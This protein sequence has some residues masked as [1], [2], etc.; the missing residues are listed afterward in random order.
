M[1][2]TT[3]RI[4]VGGFVV[5]MLGI[6]SSAQA[7]TQDS[8]QPVVQQSATS[9]ALLKLPRRPLAE[10]LPVTIY[11]FQ[12]GV[13]G[14]TAQAATEMF[15]TALIRSG[16][17]RVVERAHLNDTVMR[18]KQMNSA[19]QTDGNVAQSQLRG[20]Q[21]IFDGTVSEA[22]IA[23]D[24]HSA[25]ISIGGLTIGGGKAKDSIAIDVRILDAASGDVLDS[26]AVS[27]V[28]KG[29]NANIGGTAALA[30]TLASMKGGNASALTPDIN[31]GTA[32]KD[33]SDEALRACIEAAVL[34]LIKRV[35]SVQEVK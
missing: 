23:A 10:R 11:E 9:Q 7:G 29:T 21:Y 30:S 27:K 4:L 31:I 20:A 24:Q 19:G 13:Q 33:G 28:L 3:T 14:V 2:H 18:E 5:A 16:Q 6:Q 34:E 1:R 35:Q 22:N 26:V 12:S 17:F 25:G 32:H 15:T 8:D